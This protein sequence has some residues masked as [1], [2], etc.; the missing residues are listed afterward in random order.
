MQDKNMIINGLEPFV[1]KTTT[2][3][4]KPVIRHLISCDFIYTYIDHKL[5]GKK[6]AQKCGHHYHSNELTFDVE[7]GTFLNITQNSIVWTKTF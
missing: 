3:H 5:L 6:S 1:I 4:T 2:E 7:L